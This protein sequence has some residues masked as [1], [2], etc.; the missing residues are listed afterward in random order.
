[1]TEQ[2]EQ[3]ICIKFGVKL[4]HS[5]AE[6]IQMIQKIQKD[7]AMVMWWLAA[8][9]WQ[10]V[11]SCI[12]SHAEFFSKTSNDPGD[13]A[14]LLPR[15]GALWLLTFPKTKITFE[16]EDTSDHWWDSGKYKRE[17]D[18]DWENCVRSQGS[19]FEEDLCVIVLST[20]FLVSCI[21]FN[22]CLYFSHYMAGYFLERPCMALH[23]QGELYHT[24]PSFWQAQHFQFA[25]IWRKTCNELMDNSLRNLSLYYE[26]AID[27]CKML[28]S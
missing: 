3:W 5:S 23:I 15:F 18:G 22:N 9:S 10:H 1:M 25:A 11:R 14:L 24:T 19:C 7:T 8:S 17:A 20:M 6:T 26:N 12:T 21:F 13:S 28:S 16:R 2:V 4:E 27:R